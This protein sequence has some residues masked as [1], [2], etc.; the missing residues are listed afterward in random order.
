[1]AA[2]EWLGGDRRHRWRRTAQ[3]RS[4]ATRPSGDRRTESLRGGYRAAPRRQ[5]TSRSAVGR[6]QRPF[7]NPSIVPSDDPVSAIARSIPGSPGGGKRGRRGGGCRDRAGA[8]G[9]A[10]PFNVYPRSWR[11]GFPGGGSGA[12]APRSFPARPSSCGRPGHFCWPWATRSSMP[13]FRSRG[14]PRRRSQGQGILRDIPEIVAV[15]DLGKR[16][17][18]LPALAHCRLEDPCRAGIIPNDLNSVQ[19]GTCSFLT[20]RRAVRLHMGRFP[21]ARFLQ[22]RCY[23]SM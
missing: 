12:W 14:Q 4:S 16:L 18:A 11:P 2:A 1:M 19:F 13:V 5:T 3:T 10:R 7:A 9:A 8:C 15:E 20:W 21:N 6:R 17:E 22:D 23:V